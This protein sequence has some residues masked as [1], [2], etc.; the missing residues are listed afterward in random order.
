MIQLFRFEIFLIHFVREDLGIRD[1]EI[2]DPT[3]AAV[4]GGVEDEVGLGRGVPLA[5][6]GGE[7]GH[8]CVE[9]ACGLDRSVALAG[10]VV[11]IHEA[12]V[13]DVFVAVVEEA[14][15]KLVAVAEVEPVVVAFAD[16]SDALLV[17]LRSVV[18][19]RCTLR[20]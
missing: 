10:V 8:V 18:E 15:R 2:G 6:A 1:V 11:P 19:Q 5:H 16:E 14:G 9:L 12:V 17:V 20:R 13:E 7:V 4:F 3:V